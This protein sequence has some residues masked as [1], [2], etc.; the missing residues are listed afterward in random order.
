MNWEL[1]LE[2]A[3]WIRIALV[4]AVTLV[5]YGLLRSVIAWVTK[6][7]RGR[8]EVS[9]NR[10][11]VIVAQML[12]HTSRLLILAFSLLIGLKVVELPARWENTLA[13]GWFI[14]LAFQIALWADMAVRFWIES[15]IRDDKTR[16]PVTTT[17]IGIMVRIVVWT[18]MLLSILANLGVNITALVASLGVGGIAIALAVQ[19]LLSDVFASL[20][21]GVD[22]PFEIG[23][24]VVFGDVAGT[25]EHIGLKSTRI[26]AL[27]GEQVVCSNADLLS[28]VV[29]NYKRMSTRRIVFQ[30]GIAYGTPSDKARQVGQLLKR[31]I[32]G[33]DEAKFDRAHLLSFDESRM[34]YEVVY[35]M[36][37][38]DYNR[39]MDIQQ[40]INLALIDGLR[41]LGVSFALPMRR[42]EFIGGRLPEVKVGGL[43]KEAAAANRQDSARLLP[44]R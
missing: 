5:S 38:A 24:F 34:T 14:A 41:E 9:A 12:A 13:H 36:Q 10:L 30:F 37:T 19:T 27:S 3:L 28:Q 44:D 31:I 29:H 7:L 25:I 43:A 42:V 15:L 40:E 4:V 18:I 8:A 39:Y 20:S 1:L 23:D 2:E 17:L 26:R 6:R 35:I 33:L 21:I 22:K 16:N 32:D 11:T